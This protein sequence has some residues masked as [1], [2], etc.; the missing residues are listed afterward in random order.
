MTSCGSSDDSNAA[1]S[2]TATPAAETATV[3]AT[4]TTTIESAD[5]ERLPPAPEHSGVAPSSASSDGSAFLRHVFEDAEALWT[6]E[7]ASAELTYRPARLTIFHGQV[8]TACG[9]QTADVGPFYCPASAGVYLDTAFFT[10]L[11]HQA[12]VHLGDFAQAYVIAHEVAHHVQVLLGI[13]HQVAAADQVDPAG[14]NGRS[15][16][17]EL[18]ADCFAGVWAH[19]AYRRGDLTDADFADALRAAA[20]VG[21]DF[22]QQ[23]AT[24]TV[25]PEA[26][27]HGTSAQR[28]H[29]LTTGFE[30]GTPAACNTFA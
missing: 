22:Q 30:D 10:A 25:N 17:V 18:Q 9:S 20:V 29:W 11:S 19:S 13:S 3:T 14:K 27:T 2:S 1:R 6:H 7:F 16:R 24:G 28:Q 12:G 4:T 15:V 8:T 5:L 23:G 21:D 26:F